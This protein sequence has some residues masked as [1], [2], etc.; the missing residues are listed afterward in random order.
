MGAVYF[1]IDINLVLEMKKLPLDL[2]IETGSFEG[3]TVALVRPHFTEIHTVELSPEYHGKAAQRFAGDSGVQV[4]LGD[5]AGVLSTLRPMFA[6]R[7]TL[8]WLDAHWCAAEDTAG[9]SSQSPLLGELAAIGPL[10]PHSVVLIDDARL[11]LC[12]PGAP[13]DMD[14]WPDLAEVLAALAALSAAHEPAVINDVLVFYPRSIRPL[15]RDYAHAHG[16][17]W[18]GFTSK[19]REYDG[20]K[21]ECGERGRLIDRLTA[22][23]GE[24]LRVSEERRQLIDRLVADAEERGRLIGK[25]TADVEERGRLIDSLTVE[26]EARAMLIGRLT[27]E[28]EE[29]LRVSEE[30][31]QLIERLNAELALRDQIIAKHERFLA[32]LKGFKVMDLARFVLEP[33]LGVLCQH[34]P[35]PLAI[36]ERYNRPPAPRKPPR[37]SVVTPV[38]NQAA[39]LERTILSVF[40][41]GYPNLEYVVRDG[42]SSDGAQ[43]ILR[44]YEDRLAWVS[45]P[46]G[47]QTQALNLGFAGTSGEIMAYLN[48]DDVYLPGTLYYVA[49][50]FER[51]PKVDVV[52][53]HRVVINEQDHEV[54]R[55]VMPPHNDAVLSWADYLPQET[56]FWRRS[57]WEKAGGRFDESFQFAM[58]WD[59]ILRLRAAGARMVRL[60]RFL[61]AFR[62]HPQQKTSAAMADL[63]EREMARLR[64]RS[65]G[66]VPDPG[67]IWRNV[68]PYIL[69]HIACDRLHGLGLFKY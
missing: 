4:H 61:G 48:A 23:S 62:A 26:A 34:P 40:G 32:A 13:Q 37:I 3:D 41:Q 39:F 68:R 2:F 53:G 42:G 17:D 25:L 38:L 29:R 44:R 47:G 10:H 51:R 66:R 65:L 24:R 56:M 58:D 64:E 14:Q 5:S 19:A 28:S 63:G 45:A 52:Y 15:M 16:A 36:P 67:E 43:D 6:D 31:R 12:A 50:Y 60:P 21:A 57:I 33:R 1:S 59:L 30:R 46:D 18:L 7:A 49:A 9:Q 22:E 11:Y 35:T 69:R 20:L 55:W 27:A 8:F 54:G